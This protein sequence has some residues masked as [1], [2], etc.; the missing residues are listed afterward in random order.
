MDKEGS[1][2]AQCDVNALQS[3]KRTDASVENNEQ[4]D[5]GTDSI[6]GKVVASTNSIETK[7]DEKADRTS[8]TIQNKK[9]PRPGTFGILMMCSA[10]IG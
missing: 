5:T 8:L 3:D 2:S 10:L 9:T 7:D 1:S 4:K 6:D